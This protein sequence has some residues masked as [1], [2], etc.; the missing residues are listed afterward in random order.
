VGAGTE[1]LRTALAPY[2]DK[3]KAAFVYGSV[4]KRSDTAQSDIDLMVIGD[5]LSY[6]D[7]YTALQNAEGI[8]QRKV[9]P[10]FFSEKDWKRKA[11]KKGSFV[12][13]VCA[14]PKLFILGSEKDI[15][16]AALRSSP[17]RSVS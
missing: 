15:D 14:R 8:L 9:S 7:L 16:L 12:N 5:D 3:I 6:S 10:L 13:K 1:P 17:R 4:A 11:S 2:S